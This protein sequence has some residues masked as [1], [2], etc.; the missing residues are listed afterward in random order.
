MR[1]LLYGSGAAIG[2]ALLSPAAFAATEED[3]LRAL[4]KVPLYALLYS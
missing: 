4:G 1:K 3:R 2:L